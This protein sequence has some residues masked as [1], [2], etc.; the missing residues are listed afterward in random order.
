MAHHP[1][2]SKLRL[3]REPDT[4]SFYIEFRRPH[5]EDFGWPGLA[6]RFLIS[7]VAIGFSQ[8]IVS[9]FNIDGWGALLF[10][11]AMLGIINAFIKPIVSIISCPL[12]VLTLGFFA[13]V[14][15]AA[16]LGLTAWVAG[17]FDLAFNVD[18]FIAAFLGALV[19]S[20]VS[21]PLG[22]WA[23]RSILR[24]MTYDREGRW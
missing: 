13:L 14:I 10:G 22:W 24:P 9:G 8:Y 6:L 4:R 19:I 18:G 1:L 16:M 2:P 7:L 12:T 5:A 3:V 15:N 21:T 20:L 11:A 23:E 17:W